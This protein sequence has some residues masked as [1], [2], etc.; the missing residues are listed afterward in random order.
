VA[1]SLRYGGD[2]AFAPF[3]SLD[4]QGRPVGFHVDL[5]Q[6]IGRQLGADIEITLQ[7]WEATVEAFR[8]G[9]IDLIAMVDTTSRRAFASFLKGHA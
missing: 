7:P 3:E 2:E 9:R 8:A 4:A 5:L 1:R 6:A